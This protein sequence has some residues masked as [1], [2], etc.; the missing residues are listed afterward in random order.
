M[1]LAGDPTAMRLCIKCVLPRDG[2]NPQN[3][4]DGE[5][6]EETGDYEETDDCDL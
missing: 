2:D 1:A 3:N 5:D 6:Y 4:S